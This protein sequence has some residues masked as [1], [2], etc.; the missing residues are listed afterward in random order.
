[1]R[2]GVLSSDALLL[3]DDR[4]VQPRDHVLDLVDLVTGDEDE[5]CTVGADQLV[6]GA[7]VVNALDAIRP[8]A[9]AEVRVDMVVVP[10]PVRLFVDALVDLAEEDFVVGQAALVLVGHEPTVAALWRD[11]RI[12]A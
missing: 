6:L 10:V 8:A 3:D 4:I 9:L 2:L 5:A 12:R 1:M 7:R 11:G